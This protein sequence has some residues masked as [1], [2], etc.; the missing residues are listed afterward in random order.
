[1][2]AD[3]T[4]V[5][6][7]QCIQAKTDSGKMKPRSRDKEWF[8]TNAGE[9]KLL[10]S[11]MLLQGIVQKPT[12]GM[13]FSEKR[14]ISTPFFP[15][16]ITDRRFHLLVRFLHFNNNE[17]FDM[18]NDPNSKLYKIWPVLE[19]LIGKF[20]STYTPESE[21]AV[22]ESLLLWKGRLGWKM[23]IP[24]KRAR[25][26]MESF[27]LCE[28]KSGYVWN[29]LVYT[30][31]QTNISDVVHGLEMKKLDKPSQVVIT[32]MD[33]LL[34][35]GY[36]VYMDN[37]YCSPILFDLLCKLKTDA[38]GTLRVNRKELPS[39]FKKM[40]LRKGEF[41]VWYRNKLMLMKWADK[42]D[43]HLISTVHD[44]DMVEVPDRKGKMK[45]KPTL[46]VDYSKGMGG[47]DLADQCIVTYSIARRRLKKY[48]MK[49]FRHLIDIAV[50]NA[51]VIYRKKG[52]K[53]T[54]LKFRLDLI[55]AMTEK[56][57]ETT[58]KPK[59]AG[60]PSGEALLRL[61]A[62]HFL[63]ENPPTAN[64]PHSKKRCAFQRSRGER[65]FTAA[66]NVMFHC[67]QF[68]AS[69][70]TILSEIFN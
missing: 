30:G 59:K 22:D 47:V 41:L 1:M 14:I 67:V 8:P 48:Y 64:R 37:Y 44:K 24:K 23:Y 36:M 27:H 19:Y 35:K 2:I 20:Q 5:Y 50:F 15:E 54:Q 34:E 7:Q 21:I 60:R 55:S 49:M 53:C 45:F 68:P 52:K 17:L 61:T 62:W 38:A 31:K 9:I 57:L 33:T 56:Y 43:V 25:F 18:N 3:Q 58:V 39:D 28:S 6:A 42:R 11:V 26:G 65:Q 70:Y 69:K 4:N 13:F 46:V 66:K 32:L 16:V 12:M 40:K 29:I 51:F 10:F 63:S